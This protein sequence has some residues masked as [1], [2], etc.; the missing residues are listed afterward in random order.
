VAIN[1]QTSTKA[2]PAGLTSFT[3]PLQ[4]GTPKFTLVRGATEV[5]SF[6]GKTQIYGAAGLPSGTLDL[7][8]WSGSA[9]ASG[10]CQLSTP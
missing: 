4:P 6:D 2:A 1:G 3:V 9:S 8:Y 10:V 5:F 7:T